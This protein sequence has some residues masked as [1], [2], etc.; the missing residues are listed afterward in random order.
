M[1]SQ[2]SPN[3][4]SVL[5]AKACYHWQPVAK[6]LISALSAVSTFIG[7]PSLSPWSQLVVYAAIQST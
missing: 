7:K 1:L 6:S 2:P 5:W 3:T 4:D